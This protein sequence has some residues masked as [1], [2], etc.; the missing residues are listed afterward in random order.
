MTEPD[1]VRRVVSLTLAVLCLL[2]VPQLAHA[3][4]TARQAPVLQVGTV[5][6]VSPTAISGTYSCRT[7]LFGSSAE[8][9]V[10][11]LSAEAQPSGVSYDF[12]LLR[13][14]TRRDDA[15]STS[16]RASLSSPFA[17]FVYSGTYR[18]TVQPR[19]GSWTAPEVSRTFTCGGGN[20]TSGAL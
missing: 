16:G 11:G 20:P 12:E 17:F 7:S 3:A 14:T 5:Q 4:F 2:V 6:L 15:T 9:D 1:T 8:A 18:V 10:T 13:G 19:L